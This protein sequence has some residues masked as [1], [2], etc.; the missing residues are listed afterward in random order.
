MIFEQKNRNN[1]IPI[2]RDD[3][4]ERGLTEE[5]LSALKICVGGKKKASE[6]TFQ[7]QFW[8][9]CKERSDGIARNERPGL[10]PAHQVR[11]RHRGFAPPPSHSRPALV[12]SFLLG[13]LALGGFAA[14]KITF[15]CF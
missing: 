1:Q 14:Q 7:S 2:C 3:D 12:A 8:S 5:K 4:K 10:E 6:I 13:L 9:E 15:S 11:T